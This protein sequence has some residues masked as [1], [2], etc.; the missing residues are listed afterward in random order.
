[1]DSRIP[2]FYQLS[3]DERRA[4][5]ADRCD[6][7][8]DG[9]DALAAGGLSGEAADTISE[10]VVGTIEY[11]V[12]IATNFRIDGEDRLVPM[13]VE[14]TSVVAA[15][16][17]G[18]RMVRPTGG[19]TTNVS[20]SVMIAQ[21]QATDVNDPHAAKQ[22]VLNQADRLIDLANEQDPVLVDHGGGCQDVE[23]RVVDT[24]RGGMVV[25]H[26]IVDVQDAMGGNAVNSMAEALAP[27][28]EE[29]TGGTVQLRILS[30]LA[31]RRLAR[32]T[33]RIPPESLTDDDS[34]RSGED[35]RDRIV[36]AWAFA[37]ADPYRAATHNK[38]IMNGIDAVA[39]ATFNDWRAI[40]AGAHAYAAR[41]GYGPLTTYEVDDDGYL[42]CSIEL[43]IQVGTVGGA[44]QLQPAAQAAMD[45]LAVDSADELAGVLA[46]VGLAQNYAGL[47]ALVSEGIQT[48][49]M[50]LHA[51]NI[52][53]QA[54]ASGE[55]IDK[56]AEQLVEEDAIRQDRAEELL[57]QYS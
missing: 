18:A 14:E 26:L 33:A 46:A 2:G 52:A 19:F 11:P 8:A 5:L 3:I 39:T 29:I 48:G 47:R 34:E 53:I 16:S 12:G 38:G 35:V 57:E 21:I 28:I 30:N 51:K 1:M 20:G 17:Y 45:I 23:V 13:A 22:R 10:N 36:D 24:A 9:V 40:E 6:L 44:T 56:I 15:A 37:A 7:D 50:T 43:P 55:L 49:H 25:T 27:T 54:G 4:E 42:A 31:D 41:G 32:A